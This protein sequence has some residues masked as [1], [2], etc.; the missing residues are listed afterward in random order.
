LNEL[1]PVVE[2]DL[3]DLPVVDLR[4]PDKVIVAVGQEVAVG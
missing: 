4:D 1:E 2:A 3:E